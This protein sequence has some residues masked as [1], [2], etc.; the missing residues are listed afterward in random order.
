M[1][2]AAQDSVRTV[3]EL[4]ADPQ[5]MAQSLRH[6]GAP[7]ELA[8]WPTAPMA[9]DT[10]QVAPELDE[11]QRRVRYPSVTVYCEKIENRLTEKFRR[12]SGI[13]RIII[14]VRV[15]SNHLHELQQELQLQTEA[16]LDTLEKNRGD[17]GNGLFWSGAYEVT[18]GTVKHGGPNYLQSAKIA[19]EVTLSRD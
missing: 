8:D 7:A 18:F 4:L 15:G 2:F 10:R 16:V 13:L 6:L 17:W 19:C 1:V 12:F 11:K 9:V 3:V 5:G 14:E